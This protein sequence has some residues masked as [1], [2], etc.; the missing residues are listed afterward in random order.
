VTLP[1][2]IDGDVASHVCPTQRGLGS[3]V[4][5]SAWLFVSAEAARWPPA[6]CRGWPA[7][8][9]AGPCL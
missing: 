2:S 6:P 9:R 4:G 8:A 7:S 5:P 3:E 1:G